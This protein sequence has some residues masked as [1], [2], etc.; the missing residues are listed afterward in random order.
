MAYL[1]QQE[2]QLKINKPVTICVKRR[3]AIGDVIMTTGVVRELKKLYG[4]TAHIVVATDKLSVYQNN[5]N[6]LGVISYDEAE[7]LPWDVVFNLDD[8]Y[9]W[10]PENHY[11][12]SYFHKVFGRT[13]LDKSVEL[14]PNPDDIEIVK[15][16][17]SELG[18][19]FIVV[20]MRNWY[21]EC[22]NIDMEVWYAVLE[23]LFSERTDFNIVCVGSE[24]DLHVDHPLIFDGRNQY[25]EQQLKYLC[26]HAAC[27]VGVDSAPFWAAAASKTKIIALLTH[28]LPERIMPPGD[29]VAITTLEDC[30]GC[31]DTQQVPVRQVVCKK[32]NTPCKNNFDIDAIA[33][34]ILKTLE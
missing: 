18:D 15:H 31:N 8:A 11:L 19:K 23:K 25:T 9:E 14:F 16:D 1:A 17:L 5:P 29:H 32:G 13:D 26:D 30:R 27:F 20:H 2:R 12:D 24:S 10:N 4:E 6:V 22:K 21:W 7:K 3:A 33:Q 28:L 34:A